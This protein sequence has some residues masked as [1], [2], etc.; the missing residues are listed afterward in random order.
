MTRHDLEISDAALDDVVARL[1][2][3]ALSTLAGA[4]E[5]GHAAV[6]RLRYHEVEA[7][8]DAGLIHSLAD[9][10]LTALGRRAAARWGGADG[11]AP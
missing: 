3:A 4:H 7:L 2:D 11:V 1:P 6:H 5:T 10:R 9:G 8:H